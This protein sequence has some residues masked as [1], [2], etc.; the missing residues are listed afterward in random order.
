MLFGANL[1]PLY[2]VEKHGVRPV[3]CGDTLRRLCGKL[4][5][6]CYS[7]EARKVLF[8]G[9]QVGVG[10]KMG[11]EAAVVMVAGYAKRWS[12]HDKCIVKI[13]FANAFNT[14]NQTVFLR[15]ACRLVQR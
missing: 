10:V 2:K 7:D 8:V 14:V 1:I 12:G 5:G 13:D 15:E 9:R 4:V 11:M 3:A 6:T